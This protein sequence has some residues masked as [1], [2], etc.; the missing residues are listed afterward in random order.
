MPGSSIGGMCGG[1]EGMGDEPQSSVPSK[2]TVKR[3]MTYTGRTGSDKKKAERQRPP[4]CIKTVKVNGKAFSG[5]EKHDCWSR[6]S[7][8]NCK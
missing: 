7:L 1:N 4:K 3:H 6:G 2:L 8:R 5:R